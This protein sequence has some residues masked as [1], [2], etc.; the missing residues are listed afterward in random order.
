MNENIEL[1]VCYPCFS[2]Q[3]ER[4]ERLQLEIQNQ[5][6]KLED[7]DTVKRK[8]AVSCCKLYVACYMNTAKISNCMVNFF[9]SL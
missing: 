8:L 4:L 9:P 3:S 1:W 5:E 2:V 7:T 6:H